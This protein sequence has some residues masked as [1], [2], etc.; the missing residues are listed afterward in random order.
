MAWRCQEIAPTLGCWISKRVWSGIG[1]GAMQKLLGSLITWM[2][3]GVG[4][5]QALAGA[6]CLRQLGLQRHELCG[7]RNVRPS[8]PL[9]PRMR[10]RLPTVVVFKIFVGDLR[11]EAAGFGRPRRGASGSV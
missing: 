11:A 1:T 7:E 3:G 6:G 5:P 10:S 2:G 9:L 4:F 8:C